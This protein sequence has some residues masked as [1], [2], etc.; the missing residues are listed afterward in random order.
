[1]KEW[2]K[3]GNMILDDD[4]LDKVTEE[5]LSRIESGIFLNRFTAAKEALTL[6]VNDPYTYCKIGVMRKVYL[7]VARRIGGTDISAEHNL[8]HF[9]EAAERSA[10]A[11]YLEHLDSYNVT[12]SIFYWKASE[13]LLR[14]IL[15]AARARR[16]DAAGRAGDQSAQLV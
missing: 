11:Y 13:I 7:E 9:R 16:V 2:S 10:T 8:C 4:E 12:D 1:M 15:E 5:F 6:M 14:E 3:R